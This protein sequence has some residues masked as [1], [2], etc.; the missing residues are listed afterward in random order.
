MGDFRPPGAEAFPRDLQGGRYKLRRMKRSCL[1]GA[2]AV[3]LVAVAGEAA[4][5]AAAA[6]PAKDKEAVT[7]KEVE[8][9]I[10]LGAYAG[11]LFILNPPASSGPRPFSSGQM[12]TVE[13]GLD[14]GDRLSV[15]V[16]FSG[17]ANR[18]GADY[19]GYSNGTASGDFGMLIPGAA[20]RFNV[21]GFDDSQ[22]TTRTFIYVRGGAGYA[23]YYPAALLRDVRDVLGFGGLGVEYY[24]RLRH[25]SIGLEAVGTYL[26]PSGTVGFAFTPSLR[27]AF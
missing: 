18:E 24:T 1:L 15:G 13:V 16:F 20:L 3:A 25:F 26:V 19:I 2:V 5:Q 11:P 10:Y 7:F 4:A 27:Y 12:A 6:A 17:T 22:G 21:L 8:R 14:L 23:F 9:G